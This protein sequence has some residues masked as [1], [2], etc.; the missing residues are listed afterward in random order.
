EEKID[1]MLKKTKVDY[2]D[3]RIFLDDENV[4][5]QIRSEIISKLASKISAFGNVRLKMVELQRTIAN[6]KNVILDG[7]DI[8]TKVFPNADY[9]FFITASVEPRAKRRY[10]QLILSSHDVTLNN[11][12]EDIKKRDESDSTRKNSPL[13]KAEDAMLIDT[14]NLNINEVVKIITDFIGGKNVL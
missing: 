7:R 13:L 9:K 11:V 12:L 2:C 3:N 10:E 14:S 6:N 4:E 1:E 8:G 5:S